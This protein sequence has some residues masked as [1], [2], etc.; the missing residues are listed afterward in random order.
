M[1]YMIFIPLI[2]AIVCIHILVFSHSS[3][4]SKSP[5]LPPGPPSF[6]IIG[7]ILQLSP[8]KLH[9]ALAKLSKT[10]G[11]IITVKIGTITTVVISSPTLAK[12]ALHKKDQALASRFV[13]DSIK[14]LSHDQSSIVFLPVSTK[15]KAFRKLCATKIFSA[16]KLDSTQALRQKKLKDLLDHLHENCEKGRVVDIGEVAF[17]TVLNSI[18]NTLFSIDLASY[19]CGVSH[20]TSKSLSLT[21]PPADIAHPSSFSLSLLFFFFFSRTSHTPLLSLSGTPLLFLLTVT[22]SSFR[23]YIKIFRKIF[24]II[25]N[26]YSEKYFSE[27]F[28]YIIP[29]STFH[30]IKVTITES[31][32]R[33]YMNNN[34]TIPES[35]FRNAN[36]CKSTFRNANDCKST[37]RNANDCKRAFLM[38]VMDLFVAGLDT[39]TATIEWVMAELLCN[40]E[41]L[42]KIKR[43]LQQVLSKERELK[44]SDISKLNYLHAVVKETLRLHPTAPILIH[45]S[46]AEVD[47]GGFRVPKDAQVLVNVWSMGRDSTIWTEPNL[48]LPE[49]FLENE[50]DFRGDD[51][52]FIPFGS[53]RRMCPGIPLANRVVHTILA[54]LLFHFDWKLADGCKAKDMDMTE[55]FGITLHK[56]K[57]LMAIPIKE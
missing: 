55:N 50:R 56:V 46:V 38:L 9:Q 20:K 28:C 30:N 40:P 49:R 5:K 25:L 11:P 13:P 44:D 53:G 42:T 47:I 48:F 17:T 54:S 2:L 10:Y 39:T 3:K 19:S 14:A 43:E 29:E 51:L 24:S 6:P 15:W 37:F 16:Q 36:D 52:G 57:P 41:K 45:K 34:F 4:T 7:N 22:E 33:N 31:S 23:N 21:R 8:T 32:F 18:S 26:S 35:T 27:M 12:E 1:D